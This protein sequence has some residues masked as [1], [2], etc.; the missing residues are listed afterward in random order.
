[1]RSTECPTGFMFHNK[2]NLCALSTCGLAMFKLSVVIDR[3]VKGP[4]YSDLDAP[5]RHNDCLC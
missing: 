3:L 2:N 4:S 1:M 5:G